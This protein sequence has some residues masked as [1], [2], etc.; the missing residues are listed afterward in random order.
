[1]ILRGYQAGAVE[2]LRASFRAWPL[3]SIVLSAPRAKRVLLVSPTGSGKTVIMAEIIH[4][5]ERIRKR[6]L[7][8]AH[9]K[10]LIEQTSKKLDVVGVDHGVI[11][12]GHQRSFPAMAVQVAS[13]QTL[14]RRQPPPTDFVI[15][16][17]AHHAR[18]A[19]YGKILVAYPTAAVLGATA[20]PWRTDGKGLGELFDD[21]VVAAKP[22]ELIDAGHL[23]GYT[24][25]AYDTPELSGVKRT[26]GDYNEHGLELVMGSRPIVGNVVEQYCLHAA[27]GRAVVFAVSIAHSMAMKDRF[28]AAG[29][30]AEHLDGTTPDRQREAILERVSSGATR[31]LC[32]VN[33]VTE[34]WDVPQLEVCILARPTLSEGLYLQMVGRVLRPACLGCGEYAH[35]EATNCDRCGSVE[36][37]RVARIHDHAGCILEHG[38]PDLDR[39]YS[40]TSDIRKQKAKDKL[41][42]LRTCEKC[43]RIYE[44]ASASCPSCSH[45]NA[46]QRK[47]PRELDGPDVQ[48]IPLEQLRERKAQNA[49]RRRDEAR[50]L[51]ELR[52]TAKTKGYNPKWIG[53]QFK[54]RYGHWPRG[55]T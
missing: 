7:F 24:G 16:D 22:R 47:P 1:V 35:P 25:F 43:L 29:I 50:F 53:I 2:A 15:I 20:T 12:A 19:T 11:M 33:V 27:G 10:E 5:A 51:A 23:V 14:A 55:A 6:I 40:L 17:E 44:S 26:A 34:G 54:E 48:A 28:A 18:A 37:K 38:A 45:V 30:S 4:S 3:P 21:L 9:R 8:L 46:A 32:N 41:P 42:P 31:V 52:Q 13:V 36:I 39:D 49:V